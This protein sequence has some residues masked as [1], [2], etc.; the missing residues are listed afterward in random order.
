MIEIIVFTVTFVSVNSFK[1]LMRPFSALFL[2]LVLVNSSCKKEVPD[3]GVV[4]GKNRIIV[5]VMHHERILQGIPVYLKFNSTEFP[6]DDST[7]YDWNKTSDLSGV[8]VFEDLFDGNYFLYGKGIDMGIGLQVMG[9][10]TLL[11]N[12]STTVNDEIYFPLMV[13]E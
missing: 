6:G 4:K 13:T 1:Y 11:V 2:L 12:D 9:G 8:A 7:L 3:G 10:A 5:T